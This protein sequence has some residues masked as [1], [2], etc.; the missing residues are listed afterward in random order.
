MM[1]DGMS[2]PQIKAD[3]G[4]GNSG[5]VAYSDKEGRRVYMAYTPLGNSEWYLM[6][7]VPV[8]VVN[9]KSELLMRTTL[10]LCAAITLAFAML[11]AYQ[12]LTYS[13]HK[14]KLEQIAYVDPITGGNTIERFYELATEL[15]KR[16][17]RPNIPSSTST[18]KNSSC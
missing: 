8:E 7:F 4:M 16:R 13:R 5:V 1:E 2:L 18:W 14:H 9:A 11:V 17:A 10:L 15:I 3:M 6:G 12:M